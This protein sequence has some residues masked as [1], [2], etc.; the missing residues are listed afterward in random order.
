MR[1]F[2]SSLLSSTWKRTSVSL[3]YTWENNDKSLTEACRGQRDWTWHWP[4]MWPMT[5]ALYT[6]HPGCIPNATYGH[7]VLP[8][9]ISKH[10]TRI[11][12]WAQSG[13]NRTPIPISLQ[14]NVIFNPEISSRII[15]QGQVWAPRAPAE[16]GHTGRWSKMLASG[17]QPTTE[18][19]HFLFN[20]NVC[21]GPS[22]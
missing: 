10:R 9:V 20:T 7:S 21:T 14:A 11:K 12:S 2:T 19:F 13:V 1:R 18:E 17:S 22:K 8:G 16:V 4:C 15:H 6:A 3:W 5:L